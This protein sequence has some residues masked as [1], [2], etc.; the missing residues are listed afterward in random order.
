MGGLPVAGRGVTCSDGF[1]DQ[2]PVCSG[3][4]YKGGWVLVPFTMDTVLTLTA[5]QVMKTFLFLFAVFFFLDPGKENG[6]LYM[7]GDLW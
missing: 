3:E 2:G 1:T 6:N 4:A 5:L 7:E